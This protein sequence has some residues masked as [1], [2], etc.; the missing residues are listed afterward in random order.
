[1]RIL[2]I[3]AALAL[4]AVV[5]TFARYDTL[6]PCG[7]LQQD[8]ARALGVPPIM[9]QARVRASFMFRGITE[10]DGYDCLADWWRLKA[11]GLP[12]EKS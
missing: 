11:K 3:A 9:A 1:M 5:A 2:L 4:A 10:P 8:M 6:Y 7:W 12:E